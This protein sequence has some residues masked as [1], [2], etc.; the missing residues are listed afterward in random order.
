M[1]KS[2]TLQTELEKAQKATEQLQ[3]QLDEQKATTEKLQKSLEK[4]STLQTELEKAQKAA[5]S[6]AEANQKLIDDNKAL[7]ETQQKPEPQ[8]AKLAAQSNSSESN[9]SRQES[10]L[11][12]RQVSS[13]ARPV[14]PG[15]PEQTDLDIGWAD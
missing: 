6:L 10:A 7:K 1:E 9:L 8:S 13:L 15:S 11:R 5:V 4:S 2:S 14:F 12:Q 3:I